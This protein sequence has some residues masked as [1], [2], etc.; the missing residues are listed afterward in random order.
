M[1]SS[2]ALLAL[3]SP[4][5]FAAFPV[6]AE[7]TVEVDGVKER[8][9]GLVAKAREAFDA[10]RYAEAASVYTET[11][12]LLERHGLEAPAEILFNAG[13]A[14]ERNGACELSVEHFERFL[15]AK[16]DAGLASDFVE[17]LE[18]ARRCAPKVTVVTDPP[19]A[20]VEIDGARR[21]TAPLALRLRAGEHI[22]R[23]TLDGWEPIE[24]RIK[25]EAGTPLDERHRL[26]P[27]HGRPLKTTLGANE[28]PSSVGPWVMTSGI[29][30]GLSLAASVILFVRE[31]NAV[32]RYDAE[33]DRGPDLADTAR[34]RAAADEAT[35][36]AVASRVALGV[37][38][39]SLG[40]LA[41]MLLLDTDLPLGDASP[42]SSSGL[43]LL[44][45]PTGAPCL[46]ARF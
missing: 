42:R 45:G 43:A 31:R 3:F 24:E 4:I 11:Y 41:A 39:V 29:V 33:V 27:I 14:H 40:A 22:L 5:V 12:E 46:G 8:A 9:K 13:L 6:G 28:E 35:D 38:G 37:A 2:F 18:Q 19:E 15:E 20:R 44:A 30:G 16:P 26:T 17:R 21:G 23:L 36:F 34:A 1:A 10:G 32:S 7:P 25:V